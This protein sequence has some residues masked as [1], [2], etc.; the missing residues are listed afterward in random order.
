MTD[1]TSISSLLTPSRCEFR[2]S[3]SLTLMLCARVVASIVSRRACHR[4][5][6]AAAAELLLSCCLNISNMHYA[7]DSERF[8]YF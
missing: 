6:I 4:D 3:T 2:S 7:V 5:S 8:A 1:V